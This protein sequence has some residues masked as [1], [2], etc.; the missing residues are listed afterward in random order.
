MSLIVDRSGASHPDDAS[1]DPLLDPGL[2]DPDLIERQILDF[3]QMTAF[4]REPFIFVAGDGVTLTDHQGKQYLDGLSGVFVASIG[5]RNPRVVQAIHE[6]L[7]RLAFAPPLHGTN[8]PA[9]AL[10]RELLAFA[11]EAAPG[12]FGAVKLL[13]GGSEANEAALKLARQYWQQAGH[14]RKFKVIARYG[15]D[16]GATM[17][18]LSAT[19]GW[20]RKSVFEPLV[21]G[22]LHVHPPAC[23]RCP[24]DHTLAQCRAHDLFTCARHVERTIEAE[25]P[26]TVAAVIMEPVSV[27]SAGFTVPPREYFAMLRAA[28]D[29]H[30]V[31]LIFDEVITGFGR[32]GRRFGA[33]Y[34]GVMPDLITCGK[35]MSGGYSPLAAVLISERVR[36][37]FLGEP[38][39]RREFH[40]GH[41]FG[42]N[43]LSSATGLAVLRYIR[44]EGLVERAR[45]VGERV[46]GPRL[47]QLAAE[48]P[49]IREVRGDGLLRGFDLDPAVYGPAPGPRLERLC[50][51]RGLI[52]RIGR[53]FLCFAPPLTTPEAALQQMVDIV[54]ESVRA[55]PAGG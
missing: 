7:D 49:G 43:P 39:Q 35:G 44:Q 33:E 37:A 20:E 8:P 15:G 22:F 23:P 19:G 17:G 31:L 47:A 14:P 25:D 2:F 27:S 36:R 40:H 6:Q 45:E 13:S 24:Y 12:H 41:T 5:H 53:D 42:G 10:A 9:L 28:C 54:A 32:L 30:N 11:D 29:K 21:A 55:L 50:K 38:G 26:E 51:E 4:A 48:L 3:R 46:L 52:A 1:Q 34:Y 16:H 18:A